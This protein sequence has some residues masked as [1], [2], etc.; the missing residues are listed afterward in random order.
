MARL[1]SEAEQSLEEKIA[2]TIKGEGFITFAGSNGVITIIE[3]KGLNFPEAGY[4]N[5]APYGVES[6]AWT[7]TAANPE[8]NDTIQLLAGVLSTA[9]GANVEFV[10]KPAEPVTAR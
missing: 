3:R 8:Y 7:L 5:I 6:K 4:L 9:F 1:V 2:A 10:L